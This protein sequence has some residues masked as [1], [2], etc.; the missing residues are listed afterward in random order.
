MEGRDRE[1][2]ELTLR[3]ARQLQI[4]AF[5]DYF[6]SHNQSWPPP[7]TPLAELFPQGQSDLG[8]TQNPLTG[9][10]DLRFEYRGSE[11][12]NSEKTRV[13]SLGGPRGRAVLYGDGR[14][15]WEPER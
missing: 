15:V 11:D 3:R 5:Q 12:P 14:V 13:A 9:R 6:H 1:L 4:S 8:V 7:G 2:Q 10:D